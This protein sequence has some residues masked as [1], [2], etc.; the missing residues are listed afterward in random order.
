[1][2]AFGN[3]PPIKRKLPKRSQKS[4]SQKRVPSGKY[5]NKVLT[6][7]WCGWDTENLTRKFGK[8]LCCVCLL[9]LNDIAVIRQSVTLGLIKTPILWYRVP[10]VE[11]ELFDQML[12]AKSEG[13]KAKKGEIC[14]KNTKTQRAFHVAMP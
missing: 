12:P 6:Q 11:C 8:N 1:M 14:V 10:W 4:L 9:G 5:E 13:K 3:Q 2:V 7:T